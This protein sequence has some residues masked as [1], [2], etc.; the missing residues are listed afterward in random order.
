[1]VVE[2]AQDTVV[3]VHL[4]VLEVERVLIT[5]LVLDVELLIK[6]FLEV[7]LLV[8]LLLVEEEL[9]PRVLMVV[10]LTLLVVELVEQVWHRQ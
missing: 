9:V 3:L 1:L 7:V 8:H 5:H 4:V 6:V 2:V 10:L